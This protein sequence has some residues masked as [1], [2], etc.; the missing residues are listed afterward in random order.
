[1]NRRF[2][3]AQIL[4]AAFVL[5]VAVVA[6]GASTRSKDSAE[7]TDSQKFVPCPSSTPD[8]CADRVAQ[9]WQKEA[10]PMPAIVVPAG[11]R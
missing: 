5:V 7:D 6:I 3:Y 4:V 1:M 10:R 11:L 8:V 9:M 2:S